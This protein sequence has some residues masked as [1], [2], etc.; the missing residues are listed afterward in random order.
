M[1]RRTKIIDLAG[2]ALIAALLGGSLTLILCEALSFPA[3]ATPV[4]AL[5]GALAVL[6]CAG[7]YSRASALVCAALGLAGFLWF[8]LS[9][10]QPFQRLGGLLVALIRP[11]AATFVPEEVALPAALAL[12]ALFTLAL[13]WMARMPGGVYP[14]LTLAVLVMMGGWLV[15]R[16]LKPVYVVPA[17]AALAALFARASDERVPYLR[18]LPLG[19]IAAL[20]ALALVPAGNPTWPPLE[21]GAQKLRQLFYDYFMFTEARTTYSLYADGYQP[22]GDSLGGPADPREGEVM[23]VTCDVPLL[24]RGSI[25]R[26][27]TT[28]SWTNNAVS[29]RYLYLDPTKT[30]V[31]ARVF[32]SDRLDGLDWTGAF[33]AA[34]AEILMLN[35]CISALYVPHRLTQLDAG[36]ELAVY[37]NNSG[38]VFTT[39]DVQPGDAYTFTALVPSGGDAAMEALLRQAAARG[40]AE[41]QSVQTEYLSLPRGIEQGVY[42]LARR[43]ADS[44]DTPYARARALEEYLQTQYQYALDVDYPPRDRDFVSY[45]LLE[46]KEGYCSYFASAMAVMARMVGLPSRYI[47]GYMVSASPNGRVVSGNNAHAW[48]EIYFEGAGWIPFNPTPGSGDIN[49]GG[50]GG[51]KA[52]NVPP[53]EDDSQTADEEEEGADSPQPTPEPDA[54]DQDADE[55][56][57]ESEDPQAEEPPPEDDLPREMPDD[58]GETPA[59]DEVSSRTLRALWWILLALLLL[60]AGAWAVLRRLRASDPRRMAAGAKGGAAKLL[61]WYRAL[62]TLLEEQGQAPAPGET[63]M[64]FARR[65]KQAGLSGEELIYVTEQLTLCSYAHK[66][67]AASAVQQAEAAYDRLQA[68]FKPLERARWYARRVL[69][70]LGDVQQIP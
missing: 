29:N 68:Q 40:D 3:E 69:R 15:G 6:V 8:A 13:L 28:Y 27:Y 18:A 39:R 49:P 50:E 48:V 45:F 67:S 54:G 2:C 65:L 20:V 33:D 62:L 5:C 58:P 61:I 47:E 34:E 59:G 17:L 26:T 23:R 41:Y 21:E 52:Q 16:Q 42:D 9:D 14:A 57:D 22:M 30:A 32:D 70:G 44:A 35:E 12:G 4:Y 24:L 51:E 43:I 7:L 38:E 66:K 1:S 60:A 36:L 37:F 11:D 25:R 64:Q 46:S 55:G 53:A 19:L 31:R 56:E 63:P 10:L